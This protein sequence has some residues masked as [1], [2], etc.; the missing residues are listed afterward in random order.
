MPKDGLTFDDI[1]KLPSVLEQFATTT[2][3]AAD[4]FSKQ[5]AAFQMPRI[6][7]LFDEAGVNAVKNFVQ[8]QVNIDI[9]DGAPVQKVCGRTHALWAPV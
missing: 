7:D 6:E 1:K 8:K 9:P 2:A 5:L 3:N 4:A